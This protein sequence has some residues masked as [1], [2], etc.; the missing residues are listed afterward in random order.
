MGYEQ[1]TKYLDDIGEDSFSISFGEI[2]KII[3]EKLPESAFQYQ[4]WWSNSDSHPFMREVLSHNWKSRKLNLE[5]K[6]IEFYKTSE[7][8]LLKFVRD[9]MQ[10]NANYQPIVIKMLL[11][12]ED[13]GF[14]V[15][16]D[17]IRKKF[18]DLNFDAERFEEGERNIG[19]FGSSIDSVHKSSV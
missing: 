12:N 10:M 2:E 15:S 6:N 19:S 1:F 8:S 18:D 13:K 5:R 16:Y 14:A 7:S 11:E 4:A 17:D 9:E 3:G